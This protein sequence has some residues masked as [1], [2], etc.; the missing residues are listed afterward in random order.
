M[1]KLPYLTSRQNWYSLMII[2]QLRILVIVL[3]NVE[4]LS[5]YILKSHKL[6]F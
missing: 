4:K 1:D 6:S 3:N 2:S 5:L